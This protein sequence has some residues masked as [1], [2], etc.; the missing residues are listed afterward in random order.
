[1]TSL[2]L[3]RRAAEP[4][5]AAA[6]FAI[7][8]STRPAEVAALPEELMRMQFDAQERHYRAAHP[9]A[10]F[11]VVLEG[12]TVVGRLY[13]DDGP[14]AVHV[15]DVA[16]LPEHR[17]RGI[18]TALLEEL[19]KGDKPVTLHVER[20]NRARSLYERLGF[21]EVEGRGVYVLLERPVS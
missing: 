15:I 3:R 7:F 21:R 14:G 13:I 10:T 20:F 6:L 8:A 16:L 18:G 9:D 1:V 4:G 19:I 2:A 12:D 11:G 17:G 5:D